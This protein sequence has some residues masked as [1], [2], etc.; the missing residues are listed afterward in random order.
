[1]KTPMRFVLLLIV[2]VLL[3][4]CSSDPVDQSDAGRSDAGPDA[5]LEVTPPAPPE[6]PWLD[7]GQPDIAPPDIAWLDAGQPPVEAPVHTPC[8]E[9]WAEIDTPDT[10]L[11][12]CEPWPEGG[13]QECAA[14]EAHFLGEPGCSVIGTRCP[15]GD[16]AEDLPSDR[17]VIYVLAG[18][19]AGGEGSRS[20]PFGTIAQAIEAA[21]P[22]TIVA[23][24]KGRD[25][26]DLLGAA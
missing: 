18:S 2:A 14:D 8:P 23:L 17:P 20:S 9:G 12:T 6:I 11:V 7:A 3:G 26:G 5:D 16:W 25:G 13:Q 22:G 24:S 4:S 10:R 1:M 19:P 21:T 15:R